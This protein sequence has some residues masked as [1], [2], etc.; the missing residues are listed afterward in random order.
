MR[1]KGGYEEVG[2]GTLMMLRGR[3]ERAEEGGGRERA[4]Q[5]LIINPALRPYKFSR[6]TKPVGKNK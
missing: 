3:R 4:G 6:K 2:K 1:V 5:R